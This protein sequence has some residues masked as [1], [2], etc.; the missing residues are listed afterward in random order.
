[1]PL[2]VMDSLIADVQSLFELGL[3]DLSKDVSHLLSQ[4]G[5]E[6]DVLN[7]VLARITY[8]SQAQLFHGLET[9]SQQL[10]YFKQNFG[11]VVCFFFHCIYCYFLT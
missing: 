6:K 2:S 3:S 1:M 7:A 8:G 5:V 4:A 9:Q 11:L 10:S